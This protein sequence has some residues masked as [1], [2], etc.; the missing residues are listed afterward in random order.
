MKSDNPPPQTN[1]KSGRH[2]SSVIALV[3]I[4]ILLMGI[5]TYTESSRLSNSS[6]P[7]ST[8]L[9][10]TIYPL[11]TV[12]PSEPSR[13]APPSATA[14]AGYRQTYVNDFVVTGVPQGWLTFHGVPGGAPGGQF[15][16]KHVAVKSGEL[17]LTAYRDN[18]YQNRWVTGGL[19]QCGRPYL[20]GAFFVRS[21][22]TG[23]GPNE[24]QLLWPENNQWPP[25]IDFNETPSVHQTTATV[26]WGFANY[27]QQLI[28]KGVN[29]LA[30]HTWGV[31]WAPKKIVFVL[32]GHV[33]GVISNAQEIPRIPMRLDLEQ[34][35]KC[36]I[37]VECPKANAQ[38]QVDWVA[39]YRAT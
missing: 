14:L 30:W 38:M 13:Y 11:G 35:T 8:I 16:P 12:S 19:C 36:L 15:S 25:E 32:D 20:Y 3:I 22:S 21:R 7:S 31:I 4:A 29:M 2:T 37:H 5:L 33:W 23:L 1:S 10:K 6:N 39:E 24:V 9:P 26:H 27:T 18:Q 28:K 34:R 17:L